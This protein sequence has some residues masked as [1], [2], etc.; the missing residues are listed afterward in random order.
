V[1]RCGWELRVGCFRTS[2]ALLTAVAILPLAWLLVRRYF[3]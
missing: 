3:V 2:T 1:M